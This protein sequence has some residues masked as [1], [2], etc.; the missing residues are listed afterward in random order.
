VVSKGAGVTGEF[1]SGT[2]ITRRLEAKRVVKTQL[3]TTQCILVLLIT[4]AFIND[5]PQGGE[6]SGGFQSEAILR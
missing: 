3:S 5:D 2:V 1:I 6:N 4:T